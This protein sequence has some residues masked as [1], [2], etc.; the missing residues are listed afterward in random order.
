VIVQG[1][2]EAPGPLILQVTSK[3]LGTRCDPAELGNAGCCFKPDELH[4]GRPAD[5]LSVVRSDNASAAG[6][7]GVKDRLC[8]LLSG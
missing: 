1:E 3:H 8:F 7:E 5:F 4:G 6:A 2:H